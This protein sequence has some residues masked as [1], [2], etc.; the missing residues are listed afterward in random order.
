MNSLIRL[1]LALGSVFKEQGKLE[2]ALAHYHEAISIDPLFA[3][4]Y[5]NLGNTY[6]EMGRLEEALK[7]YLTAVKIRPNFADAFSNLAAAYK[8]R[9]ASFVKK[10]SLKPYQRFAQDN[11]EL[12]LAVE[13]YRKALSLKPSH[14]DTRQFGPYIV[15]GV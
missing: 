7:C 12:Q 8:V 3:D 5:S 14:P 13:T 15:R 10:L 9:S 4:A 1:Y 6:K 11:N 2:Q